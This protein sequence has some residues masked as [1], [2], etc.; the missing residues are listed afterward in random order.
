MV[1]YISRISNSTRFLRRLIAVLGALV[2]AL[3][4]VSVP[5]A[6]AH[7]MGT[8]TVNRYA[9]LDLTATYIRIKYILDMAEIPT[10]QEMA[11]IDYDRDR[12]VSPDESQTYAA[13]KAEGIR[14]N[15]QLTL[16]GALTPLETQDSVLSVLEA[17]GGLSTL[18]LEAIF[19]SA[20]LTGETQLEAT[21]RDKNEPSR[22]GW[23]EIVVQSGEGTSLSFSSAPP[24]DITN[25]LRQYPYDPLATPLDRREANFS[26]SVVPNAGIT[27]PSLEA[28]NSAS[29][30]MGQSNDALVLIAT[31]ENL[32]LGTLLLP[33][34]VSAALGATHALTP[35]HGK[36]VVYTYLIGSKATVKHALL[37]GLT[38]TATHTI[39]VYTLGL[40]TLVASTYVLPE[41]LYP[42]LSLSSGLLVTVLGGSL[43]WRRLRTAWHKSTLRR[44]PWTS[45]GTVTSN[46]EY[47]HHTSA[48]DDH[49]GSHEHSH[50][51]RNPEAGSDSVTW[52]GVLALGI[53][54]GLLPCPSALS[55]MLATISLDKAAF[56]LVMVM[57]FSV[58][59][60]SVLVGIGLL[61]VIGRQFLSKIPGRAG[62][63]VPIPL[64]IGVAS[65]TSPVL[66]VL[67]G[68]TLTIQSTT[69]FMS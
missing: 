36:A 10:F 42:W 62:A 22:L 51:H 52:R 50:S 15:L 23:R 21:F 40:I 49:H 12:Q 56:G 34:A 4:V 47:S 7:P 54:G 64:F 18:R 55:L 6:F 26:F 37:L 65:A 28:R 69:Q 39:G 19:T 63:P 60:S 66:V 2:I 3:T 14:S 31:K 45:R 41:N 25:E 24:E 59:L 35:G 30:G 53:S 58:G 44:R 17:Q 27:M 43:L 9:R 29:V 57:A 46:H 32:G 48:E 16:N 20:A 33:L 1:P 5:D 61:L 67:V 68:L 13:Y 8:F 11:I 38:V